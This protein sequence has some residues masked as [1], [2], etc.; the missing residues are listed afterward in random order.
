MAIYDERRFSFKGDD[1]YSYRNQK[2]DFEN[3]YYFDSNEGVKIDTQFEKDKFYN[4]HPAELLLNGYQTTW[5]LTGMFLNLW[6]KDSLTGD[7]N[8]VGIFNVPTH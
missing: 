1:L 6:A 2:L 5:N 4:F 3:R 8:M 7:Q